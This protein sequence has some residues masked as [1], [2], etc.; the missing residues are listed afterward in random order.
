MRVFVAGATGAI[1]RR[2]VPQLV[3]E[4]HEVTGS[5][6]SEAGLKLLRS[7]GARGVQV[8]VFEV[9]AVRDA[10]IAAEPDVVVHQLTD[11]QRGSPADNGRIRRVGTRNLI[12]A[13][14]QA[15]VR[16]IVAQ[17]MA[18]AY[19]PG[20]GP[21]TETTPLDVNAPPPR[22]STVDGIRAL[23]DAAATLEEHVVLR[24]GLFYGPGT[25]YHRDGLAA[26][27]LRSPTPSEHPA[28]GLLGGMVADDGVTSFVHIDDAARAAVQA[29]QWPSGPVN[30]VDDE[31]APA[32][33]WLTAFAE[34][35]G[36]PVPTRVSGRREWQRGADNS[37]ARSRGW[38]PHFASWREGF[39]TGLSQ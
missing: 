39:R 11:L 4:G 30:I 31:P 28:A 27:V 25:W 32:G 33:E 7:Y 35:I 13:A 26:E 10:L 17:S 2:L 29:L 18:W 12:T 36:A 3:A 22:G 20:D 8:D 37:L 1:G 19:L 34:E 21:A 5:T 9:A 6:R 16:R 15:G 24:Y 38:K 14:R 23:E